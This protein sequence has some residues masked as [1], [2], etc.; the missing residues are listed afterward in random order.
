MSEA[1]GNGIV[2]RDIKPANIFIANG[3]RAVILDFGLVKLMDSADLTKSGST[4]GTA[5]YMSPE[6]VRAEPLDHRTD[7]WSLGVILYEMLVGK[8][9]FEGEYEQALGY[10]I[11][12]REPGFS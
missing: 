10:S 3:D 4:L 12:E 6:Q 8:R 7:L 2:H 5:R 11:L 1:H 9:P